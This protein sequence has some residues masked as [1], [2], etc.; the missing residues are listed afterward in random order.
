MQRFWRTLFFV[1]P[2]LSLLALGQAETAKQPAAPSQPPKTTT[3]VQRLGA[4]GGWTAY[5]FK[6]HSGQVCYVLGFPVKREAPGSKRKPAV[7]MVTHRPQEHVSD[8]VS[9]DEGYRFKEGSDASL[10]I[11]GTKFDLFTKVDTAWSR[12]ADLDKAIVAAMAKGSRA[13]IEGTPQ[14]GPPIIDTYSL[15]GF[16]RALALS[17]KACGITR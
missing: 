3:A 17:D 14:K 2:L 9:L 6:A 10:D 1:L 12:T 4:F 13:A 11:D 7:M 15:A 5:T 16:S 8:V